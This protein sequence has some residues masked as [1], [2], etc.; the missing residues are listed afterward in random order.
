[1]ADSADTASDYTDRFT[2][3]RLAARVR[4]QGVS[5]T[6]CLDCDEAIPQRRRESLP[7][8]QRCVDCQDRIERGG[9][10]TAR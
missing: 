6:H 1:M 7:G 10:T 8:V 5:R 3:D 4:Y 9:R 2:A